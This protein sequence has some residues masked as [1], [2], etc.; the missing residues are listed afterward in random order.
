MEKDCVLIEE[1]FLRS[2][3]PTLIKLM[4]KCICCAD[5]K[6]KIPTEYEP[7]IDEEF[8]ILSGTHY[9]EAA[10]RMINKIPH[11]LSE[12]EKLLSEDRF[13]H[14]SLIQ[15]LQFFNQESGASP[16]VRLSSDPHW[17]TTIM[18]LIDDIYVETRS[19]DLPAA[20]DRPSTS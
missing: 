15:F 17:K 12:M 7:C 13:R 3:V 14:L 8:H 20:E 11:V 2:C 19:E 10:A 6:G 16:L 5:C 9:E 18:N 4:Q 1:L